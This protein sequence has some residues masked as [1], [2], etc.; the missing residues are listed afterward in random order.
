MSSDR[1]ESLHHLT[2]E[3]FQVLFIFF[4]VLSK[5]F[6]RRQFGFQDLILIFDES[7]SDE[8]ESEFLDESFNP[9]VFLEFLVEGD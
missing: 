4:E 5:G 3:F 9:E 7:G 2:M 1:G 6:T 8:V